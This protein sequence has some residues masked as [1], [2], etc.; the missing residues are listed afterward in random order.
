MAAGKIFSY[1][2]SRRL[3]WSSTAWPFSERSGRAIGCIDDAPCWSE[4]RWLPNVAGNE[5]NSRS[6]PVLCSGI[7]AKM[8]G[9][10]QI[11]DGVLQ[12]RA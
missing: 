12:Y 1:C 3:F 7:L 10:V 6:F 8:S 11:K 5:Q 9:D 4:L 2:R